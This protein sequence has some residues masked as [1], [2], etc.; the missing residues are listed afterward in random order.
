MTIP[1][2]CGEHSAHRV[3]KITPR[4]LVVTQVLQHLA[5]VPETHCL[6]FSFVFVFCFYFMKRPPRKKSVR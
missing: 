1:G 6:C 4:D 2:D 5:S 3:W